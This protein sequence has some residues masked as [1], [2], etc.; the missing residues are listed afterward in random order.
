MVCP[1]E[2]GLFWCQAGAIFR[3]EEARKG[4]TLTGT[5]EGGPRTI[6]SSAG[7]TLHLGKHGDLEGSL[8]VTWG[9]NH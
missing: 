9:L 8:N 2:A 4:L 6:T 1:D 7:H 3:R 5:V